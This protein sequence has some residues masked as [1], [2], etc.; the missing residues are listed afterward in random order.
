[1]LLFSCR[2]HAINEENQRIFRFRSVVVLKAH[3]LTS[4]LEGKLN[5]WKEIDEELGD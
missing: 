2:A 5:E 3:K 1:M 4:G